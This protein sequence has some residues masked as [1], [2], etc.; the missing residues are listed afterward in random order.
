MSEQAVIVDFKLRANCEAEFFDLD[1][2]LDEAFSGATNGEYDGHE[3]NEE[4]NEGTLYFYGEDADRLFET[5]SIE[6]LKS[7]IFESAIATIRYGAAD[8]GAS[9]RKVNLF[10]R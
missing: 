9:E 4:M 2:S 1:R 5:V 8:E 7:S 10:N 6:L 3:I